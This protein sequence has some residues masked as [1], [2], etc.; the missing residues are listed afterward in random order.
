MNP[1]LTSEVLS[2]I[3]STIKH[4]HEVIMYAIHRGGRRRSAGSISVWLV[5]V[6]CV[7]FLGVWL[8]GGSV[9]AAPAALAAEPAAGTHAGGGDAPFLN[10]WLLLGPCQG[11]ED[12]G[13][14]TDFIDE[15]KAM[16][17][18]GLTM[19]GKSWEAWDDR[20]SERVNDF[21]TPAERI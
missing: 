8:A 14:E 3:L 17:R 13:L 6:N 1:T 19:A 11:G 20:L 21:E 18:A 7:C 2:V 15:A 16:P 12:L 10:A 4:W 5:D 9:P